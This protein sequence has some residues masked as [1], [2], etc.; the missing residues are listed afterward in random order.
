MVI[1]IVLF[2]GLFFR[3]T[4]Q[5]MQETIVRITNG[6][7]RSHAY[8]ADPPTF[9][10]I[11]QLLK[12]SAYFKN[13]DLYLNDP[14]KKPIDNETF[15]HYY[16]NYIIAM[17]PTDETYYSTQ[18][19]LP[20]TTDAAATIPTATTILPSTTPTASAPV[21]KDFEYKEKR[22]YTNSQ[23]QWAMNATSKGVSA[24][25]AARQA[26]VPRSTLHDKIHNQRSSK[27]GKPTVLR[28]DEE[29]ILATFVTLLDGQGIR[30]PRDDVKKLVMGMLPGER[31]HPFKDD[32]PHRH[33]FRGFYKRNP[34]IM[35]HR[36]QSSPIPR[37]KLKQEQM[38]Q[39][40]E[41]VQRLRDESIS[42]SCGPMK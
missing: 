31:G 10:Y 29:V 1:S 3:L 30:I 4:D 26:H 24:R 14:S 18:R 40:F 15:N 20:D 32:G 25:E 41:E 9:S 5:F 13:K 35:N 39:F 16:M 12:K 34:Q 21:E 37:T 8:K 6:D 28:S 17:P 42:F 19:V 27:P 33:W 7:S 38:D 23:L 2:P 22:K 36:N 11:H